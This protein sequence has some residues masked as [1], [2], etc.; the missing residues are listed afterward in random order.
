MVVV[1][2]RPTA[3]KA[4]RVWRRAFEPWGNALGTREH[5][6]L[7]AAASQCNVDTVQSTNVP[8]IANDLGFAA[9]LDEMV[10]S[11]NTSSQHERRFEAARRAVPS[12]RPNAAPAP[13]SQPVNL[14]PA[15]PN[16][17][18][19]GDQVIVAR[20]AWPSY[21]CHEYIGAGG[22]ATVSGASRAARRPSRSTRHAHATAVHTRMRA[23]QFH[24]S[25]PLRKPRP[26]A[27]CSATGISGGSV[28]PHACFTATGI[29][30]ASLRLSGVI[31][32]LCMIT[33]LMLSRNREGGFSAQRDEPSRSG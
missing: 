23:S 14:Q 4:A 32:S 18:A 16:S 5:E 3:S 15:D 30:R 6:R 2:D 17:L 31:P 13:S 28:L 9:I 26:P 7:I 19:V 20:K 24:V 29:R 1:G 11:D 22:S 10:N 25:S 27:R 21:T 8:R 12:P 33:S